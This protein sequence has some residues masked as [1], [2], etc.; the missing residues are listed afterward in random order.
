MSA[1]R[2]TYLYECMES[3]YD[4]AQNHDHSF[5]DTPGSDSTMVGTFF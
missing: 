4:A 2:V 5:M 3:A 1:Q